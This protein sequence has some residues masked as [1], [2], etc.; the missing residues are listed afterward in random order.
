MERMNWRFL[1]IALR[2][3]MWRKQKAD[4]SWAVLQSFEQHVLWDTLLDYAQ[5]GRS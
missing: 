5:T 1:R 3:E 4:L 2:T